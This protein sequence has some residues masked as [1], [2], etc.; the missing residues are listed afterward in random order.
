MQIQDLIKQ[1][2]EWKKGEPMSSTKTLSGYG[3]VFFRLSSKELIITQNAS[4][5]M[6]REHST[7]IPLNT[8]KDLYTYLKEYFD[9]K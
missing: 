6:D 5:S 1:Y 7:Y 2:E 8:A 4:T 3:R 9:E